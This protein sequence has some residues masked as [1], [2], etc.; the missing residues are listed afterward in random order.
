M[1][2]AGFLKPAASNNK[3]SAAGNA[4]IRVGLPATK[5]RNT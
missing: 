4:V 5:R 3:F 2:I 1:L